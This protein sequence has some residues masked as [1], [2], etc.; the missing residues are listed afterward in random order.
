M[1][2]Q[3]MYYFLKW[4][5]CFT[6]VML[7]IYLF[8]GVLWLLGFLIVNKDKTGYMLLLVGNSGF[9]IASILSVFHFGNLCRVNSMFGPLQ[10]SVYRMFKDILKF[11]TIFLG[12]FLGFTVGVRNLYSYNR[13]LQHEI[14]RQEL[15]NTDNDFVL[16]D[17]RLGT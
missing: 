12:L 14:R 8:S 16:T 7:F 4:W 2:S 6:T 17:H 15:N 9:S 13:S 5:N 1:V 10:L 11:L 3:K